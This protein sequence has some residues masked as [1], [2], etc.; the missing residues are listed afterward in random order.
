VQVLVLP[1]PDT[2]S[3][4]VAG[5]LAQTVRR[6]PDV[7]LGLPTGRTMIPVYRALVRLHESGLADFSRATTFNL[8]EFTGLPP[9]H[10][11]AFRAYM[12]RHLFDHVNIRRDAAHFPVSSRAKASAYDRLIERA[13]GLDLCLVGI[14]RNG[15]IGFNEPASALTAETHRVQLTAGTRRGN[16]YLFGDDPNT[17]P[18][19]AMSMGIGTILRA[20]AVV[21]LALGAAKADIV[22]RATTG[23]VTT[24]LPASL[25]QTHPNVV[26]V[27]DREA[28]G[29]PRRSRNGGG[30]SARRR[31]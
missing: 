25:L 19:F 14:G 13:G 4:A 12:W 21:L 10:P 11:G 26:V 31:P 23:P 5:F 8:D 28:A 22:R 17:V 20:R 18:K 1:S 3:L 15:H 24:R 29:K 7:V 6:A 9:R 30:G 27:L 16:A 2:A